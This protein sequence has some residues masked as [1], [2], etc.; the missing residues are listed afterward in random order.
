MIFGKEVGEAIASDPTFL[1][2]VPR[3]ATYEYE[4][5]CVF[6]KIPLIGFIDSYTP[7]S[8]LYEYKTGRKQWDEM[9]AHSHGQIDMY[10]LMLYLMHKVRPAD[11]KCQIVWMP[12]VSDDDVIAFNPDLNVVTIETSRTMVDILK[13]GERIKKTYAA[14]QDYA[15][16]H[17]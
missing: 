3:A 6:N 8:L 10:L 2:L 9:R 5:R 14:M 15:N 7:H 13:F 4:L 11:V 12:T 17:E 1:P 16:N